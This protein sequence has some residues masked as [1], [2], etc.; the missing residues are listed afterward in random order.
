MDILSQ[1]T[2]AQLFYRAVLASEFVFSPD[3]NYTV[4][5]P[6]DGPPDHP[7]SAC[8]STG[9][10]SDGASGFGGLLHFN[11]FDLSSADKMK[12]YYDVPM[13]A[14]LVKYMIVP[15]AHSMD[16]LHARAPLQDKLQTLFHSGDD[17]QGESGPPPAL[18]VVVDRLMVRLLHLSVDQPRPRFVF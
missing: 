3:L 12:Q 5:M 7:D 15:E 8:D 6:L 17:F 14:G 18:K 16:D 13:L 4:F 2:D 1:Q 9:D 11:G 10:G